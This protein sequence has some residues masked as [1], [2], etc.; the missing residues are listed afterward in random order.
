MTWDRRLVAAVAIAAS[1]ALAACGAP[2]AERGQGGA[3]TTLRVVGSSEVHSI[4]P[5]TGDGFFTRLRVA[6]TLVDTDSRGSLRPCLAASWKV[7]AD[8]REWTFALRPRAVFH[9]GTTVTAE[10]VVASLDIARAKPA[11]PLADAPIQSVTAVNGQ[12]RVRLGKPYAPLP[13]VLAHTSAQVLAP[14]S[15]GKDKTVRAIIG[16]GPYKVERI[17]Q[18]AEIDV[19]A[20]DHWAGAKPAI[21]RVSYQAVGRAETRAL[22]AESG[23]AQVTFGLDAV[24]RQ[25]VQR[26]DGVE[27]RSVTL[28]R[29]ILLKVNAGHDKLSD[30]RVRRAISAALD[31]EAMA[32][33]LL[34]DPEMAATQLFPPTLEQWHQKA[35]EP[36]THNADSARELL[37]Q[38]GWS[39]GADGVLTKAGKR[40][41][42]TLRT[43]PDR[44]ELPVLATAVQDA[45]KQVGI[46]V[47]VKVGNSS[48]IPAGH[49]DG[50][51]EL[52]MFA[53]NF[54]LVPDPLAT[55]IGDYDPRG[56]DWGAMGWSNAELTGTLNALAEGADSTRAGAERAKIT[57]ILH[58]DLPL[59]PVAW[60]RQS[61]VVSDRVDGFALDPL[62]RSW[63]IDTLRWSS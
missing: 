45:L 17:K 21:R 16:T 39:P 7:S 27:I 52:A 2:D 20:F 19:V 41:E 6:E 22:M 11:T 40:F 36:L 30:V 18:P 32:T 9:D 35:V 1:A 51:L 42:V 54:A 55:L 48:E 8:Q 60:Y 56:A 25:R 26:A 49:Q 31:R 50:T 15:Y 12:V 62:E 23:Q 38:A 24:S 46:V 13:A 61:A 4:D 58:R 3:S 28:P 44:P 57:G 14:A 53:R 33:A 63:L 10:A 34:R 43:F 29:T 47:N 5:S 37:R 59:I